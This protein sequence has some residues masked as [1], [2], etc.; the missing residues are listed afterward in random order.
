LRDRAVEG[1]V[2]YGIAFFCKETTALVFPFLLMLLAA[3]R[4][5]FRQSLKAGVPAALLGAVYFGFRSKIV[6]FGGAGDVHGFAPEQL[7]PTLLH[8]GESFWRQT[9]KG[10]APGVAGFVALAVSLAALRRPRLLAAAVAFLCATAVLYWG[11]F[12]EYQNNVLIHHLDFIGRLY[13]VPVALMLMMLALERRAIA[14]AILCVPIAYG[15]YTTW[16]DHARFQRTYKRIYRTA[17]EAQRK[18]LMV[19]F[20]PKPLN[21]DV[22]GVIVGDIPGAPVRIDAKTGRVQF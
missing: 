13:L 6:A 2:V 5:T 16:R 12:G 9:L 7:W 14:I 21:D 8:L 10:S 1:G 15:G 22:R 3:R 11:M 18:P 19:H 4:I 17:S 20:P